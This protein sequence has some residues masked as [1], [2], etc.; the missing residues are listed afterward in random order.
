VTDRIGRPV[1]DEVVKMLEANFPDFRRAYEPA[2]MRPEEFG[3][4]GSTVHTL[5]QFIGAYHDLLAIIRERM[6]R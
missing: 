5:K 3:S 1:R 4:F 6:I 2:G